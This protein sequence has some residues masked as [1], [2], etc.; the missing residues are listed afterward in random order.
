MFPS[1]P[2]TNQ[3]TRLGTD[4]PSQIPGVKK[5]HLVTQLAGCH[6][7]TV[8]KRLSLYNNSQDAALD[9]YSAVQKIKN[10]L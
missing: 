9:R 3:P 8:S 5:P 6:E 1:F 4:F 2:K 10:N 7:I